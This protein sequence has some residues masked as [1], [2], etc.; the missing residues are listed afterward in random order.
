VANYLVMFSAPEN[1][2]KFMREH[3]GVS[4]N[5]YM[6]EPPEIEPLNPVKQNIFDKLLGRKYEP[7]KPQLIEIPDDWPKDEAETIDMEIN[8]RNV[9][10]YHWILNQ[11]DKPVDGAGSIFQTWLGSKHDALS[12]DSYNEDFA[13]LPDK[14]P[15]LLVLVEAVTPETLRKSFH[16]WC[17]KIEKDHEPTLEE[18]KEMHREF[19]NFS[20]NLKDAIDKNYGLVWIVS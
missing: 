9:D 8:H 4:R 16:E 10:L 1:H 17:R 13:F 19:L 14:L 6:G 7:P 2:I 11:T 15:E 12:L 20:K 18:V 3:S 5:Y